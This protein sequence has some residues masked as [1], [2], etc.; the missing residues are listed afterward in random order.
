MKLLLVTAVLVAVTFAACHNQPT[1]KTG[2]GPQAQTAQGELKT[3][4]LSEASK[5]ELFLSEP[6][7]MSPTE[8]AWDEF[9]RLYVAEMLD[10]PEDPP[11]GTP[12]RSRIRMLEDK[13]GDGVYETTTIFAEHVLEVSGLHPW[14]GGLLVTAAPDILWLKDNDGDGKADVRQVLYTG[15]P[16]VNPEARITNLRYGLD[17]WF[18]GAQN[19]NDGKVT[20]PAH[21]ERPPILIRGTDFRFNPTRDL[22][23]AASGPAQFGSSFDDFGNQFITQ[24]TIHLRHVIL[25]MQYIRRAPLLEVP[26]YAFDI[27]DHGKPSAQIFPLT[28]PQ[29]WRK[30]RTALRQQRY[31]ENGLNRVE[32]V[33]GYFSGASGGTVYNGD[34]FPAEYR[35]N[36]FTGDVS[37]N[38]IHRDIVK[39]D[40]V[41]FTASRS[42]NN[43]EFLA[44]TDVW[45]R[46][47]NFAN[48]PDGNL[49]VMDIYRLFIET[50]ESI[51]EEIKKG[52]DFYA[53]DK[54]GRIWRIAPN[55][56][57]VQRGLKVNLGTASTAELVKTL[58]HA[59]GW[60][61]FT[62]QRL[63][64][65]R[66]DKAAI[67]YL[68]ELAE[69]SASPQGRLHA[70]W[71]LEGL[72]ALD[73]ALIL[74]ALKDSDA[75][76]REHG[77]RLAESFLLKSKALADAT[78]ATAKD[79]DLRVQFQAAFTLGQLTDVRALNAL[80][81]LALQRSDDQWFRLAILSSAAD[82]AS[83]F[84]ALLRTKKPDWENA[85]LFTQLAALVGAKHEAGELT[86]FL[87]SLN[88]LKKPEVALAGL[89]K[90]IKLAGVKNLQAAQAEAL[91][92][93][94]LNHSNDKVQAA[95][96]DLARYFELRALVTKATND[97]A[98]TALTMPKRVVAVR[99]LR[100][101]QFAAVQPI[102]AKLLVAHDT[103]DVQSAAIESLAAFDEQNI[104]PL[105]L[106]HWKSYLPDARQKVLNALL[107]NQEW[108]RA[109]LQAA[110]DERIERTAFD[111]AARARL[112]D[113][114]DKAI[115]ERAQ[116]FFKEELSDRA[117]VVTA[118]LDAA[119][120]TG[121]VARG[122][123]YFE[124]NCAK[125]HLP[126]REKAR[127][128]A[129]LSGINNKTKEELITS[130]LNP[131]KAIEPR[132]VNYI[133]TTK[134]GH[135][136]DGVLGNETPGTLTLRGGAEGDVTILRANIANIRASALSLMPDGFEKQFDQQ[137]LADILAYLRGG[138]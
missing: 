23:E 47:C 22:A 98:N 59:N 116:K 48:A 64:V 55:K 96:W 66:Q 42:L 7:V 100:G 14:K 105:L 71:T 53:G 33:G 12:A 118:Y 67:P 86:R 109:L 49:Y 8:M 91:L 82:S 133:V 28:E 61:R 46:P 69:K 60:H 32:Q 26:A 75:H 130:I 138:L 121:D 25:P 81:D 50:P 80:A 125:C 83:Q 92:A 20:S 113:H 132:F 51:P 44:A 122:K 40:G 10:Y 93:P 104:A 63:L 15:F 13:D 3:F 107:T 90:G 95:A 78:L 16:M 135:I 21:P 136:Y 34:N 128:G 54:L 4:K 106:A 124:D 111:P 85:D 101:G 72:S 65:E 56:P 127:I 117:Q 38:L 103:P 88:K 120:L 94:Y 84:Y 39:P 45:F 17:N 43:T 24:N 27:S 137:A 74:K 62:A 31:N 112:V 89:A 9:G 102:L 99:A 52:M 36:V 87:A 58:E 37:A 68:K 5:A 131:S 97:A 115:S 11:P 6:K 134:D 114:P 29:E 110:E 18:Y 126:Q 1:T 70:L 108:M 19:G 129:D 35:N 57:N 76:L 73:E 79:S 119:K 77:L 2:A 123:K 41:T 30:E